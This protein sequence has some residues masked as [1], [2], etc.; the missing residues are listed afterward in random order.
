MPGTSGGK[1]SSAS[2]A[3]GTNAG[4]ARGDGGGD[5]GCGWPALAIVTRGGRIGRGRGRV[6]GRRRCIRQVDEQGFGCRMRVCRRVG[7]GEVR[8]RH[9]HEGARHSLARRAGGGQGA[10]MFRHGQGERH[11]TVCFARGR[12]QQVTAH[13]AQ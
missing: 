11:E 9:R 8:G 12:W 1:L 10:L 2:K 6:G 4:R 5:N 7:Q 13:A 3:S